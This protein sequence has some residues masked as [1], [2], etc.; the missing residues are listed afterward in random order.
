[1][2]ARRSYHHRDLARAAKA[3]ALEL[4]AAGAGELT[5]PA[6]ARSLGVSHAALYR[7]F[8][9]RRGLLSALAQDGY[10]AFGELIAKRTAGLEGEALLAAVFTAYLDFA[11][12]HPGY[13]RA[14]FHPE[15]LDKSDLPELD[16][17]ATAR[18]EALR[19]LLERAGLAP[20]PE[21]AALVWASVHGLAV[22]VSD[23]WLP[24]RSGLTTAGLRRMPKTMARALMSGLASR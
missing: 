4:L 21:H 6:V 5:L 20:T 9:G 8:A 23:G 17:V 14:L 15:L 24:G 3:R 11:G 19:E 12:R 2:A 18:F 1:M 10:A 16:R 7:H 13:F 22:L